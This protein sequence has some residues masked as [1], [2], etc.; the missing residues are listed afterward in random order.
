[1]LHYLIWTLVK[2]NKIT[3]SNFYKRLPNF[4]FIF[5]QRGIHNIFG[6]L[7][8]IFITL[9]LD[10]VQQSY[11][12]IFG[13][14]VSAYN[15]I[16]MG[17]P[18]LVLQTSS[19]FFNIKNNKYYFSDKSFAFIF[20]LKRYLTFK[21]LLS[22]VIF[23]PI[24]YLYFFA[25]GLNAAHDIFYYW[26]LVAFAIPC[27]IYSNSFLSFIEGVG[28]IKK[29]YFIKTL[30]IIFGSICLWTL[31]NTDY[32]LL[33]PACIIFTT[34]ASTVVL[35]SFK[36]KFWFS[37]N[38]SIKK[39]SWKNEMLPMQKKV[40]LL[41]VANY[42]FYF[43]PTLLI[44]P[45]DVISAGKIGLSIIVISSILGLSNSYFQSKIYIF[46]SHYIKKNFQVVN[47]VF[48][49]SLVFS[50]LIFLSLSLFFMAIYIFILPDFILNRMLDFE[51]LLLLF[52]NF[53]LMNNVYLLSYLFRLSKKY[54]FSIIYFIVVL[55]MLIFQIKFMSIYKLNSILYSQFFV[56]LL[57]FFYS[58]VLIYRI[59]L[60]KII[61]DYR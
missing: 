57:P 12:Y 6:L 56:F 55:I 5:L 26:T 37:N 34:F 49:K 54:K 16:E 4:I 59:H 7:T 35:I 41:L 42:I 44:F 33:G 30:A 47:H 17:L 28:E 8:L 15:L 19:K 46:T 39:L 9:Y 14:L 45:H 1:L 23:I 38:N 20:T 36:F 60:G 50:Q 43:T 51:S 22:L 10:E 52:F 29:A 31:L 13:S 32:Y 48:L 11:Y 58:I 40:A 53:F 24:G 18:H 61:Y 3:L 27:A 21:S 2:V 25:S